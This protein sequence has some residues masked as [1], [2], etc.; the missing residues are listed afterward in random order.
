MDQARVPLSESATGIVFCI[1][2]NELAPGDPGWEGPRVF[3]KF[4]SKQ[5][6][7]AG[8]LVS[9][10]MAQEICPGSK[11]ERQHWGSNSSGWG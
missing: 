3:D 1:P 8:M 4:Q 9:E 10:A 7:K 11:R 5:E 2:P 6:D